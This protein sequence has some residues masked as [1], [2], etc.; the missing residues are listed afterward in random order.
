MY[1]TDGHTFRAAFAISCI[2]VD[3]IVVACSVTHDSLVVIFTVAAVFDVVHVV[4]RFLAQE[5]G[6]LGAGHV[7]ALLTSL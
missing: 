3:N 6:A 5:A 7:E 4:A 2:H 1:W